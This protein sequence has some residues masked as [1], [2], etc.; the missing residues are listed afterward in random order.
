VHNN[1]KKEGFSLL[2]RYSMISFLC[3]VIISTLTGLLLS[4]FLTRNTLQLDAVGTQYFIQ[5]LVESEKASLY[6]SIKN[7]KKRET[8]FSKI[9]KKIIEN[10][11]IIWVKAY[12]LDGTVLW[13]NDKNFIGHRFMPNP[14]LIRALAGEMAVSSGTS[15]KPLKGEHVFDKE[16]PYFAEIYLPVWNTSHKQVVGVI[17]IY[18]IPHALFSVINRGTRLVWL[19]AGFGGFF[20]YASLFWIVKRA[21]FVLR[22]QQTALKETN[23]ALKE[24]IVDSQSTAE[25]LSSLLIT[26]GVTSNKRF[27]HDCVR[28]LAKIYDVRYASVGIFSDDSHTAIR[29][30]AVWAGDR[31]VDNFS[32]TLAG[33]PCEDVIDSRIEFISENAKKLYP[34]SV[35]LMEMKVNSY[36][37]APLISSS[38]TTLGIV[39]IMGTQT[40]SLQPWT[41]PLLGIMANRLALELERQSADGAL[42]LAE[43]VFNESIEAILITDQNAD[44][45][46]VNPAF[47]RMTG[48]DEVD[49]IGKNPKLLSANHH[50]EAFYANF[51]HALLNDGV[52]RGEIWNRRKNGEVFPVWQNVSSVRNKGGKIVQFISISSDITEKKASEERIHHL[53]HFDVL[54]DLPNRTSFQIEFKRAVAHATRENEHMA[55]LFLDIDHFKLIND[56]YG[57]LVGDEV[58]KHI[59]QCLVAL[60]REEDLIARLGGDEFIILLPGLRTRT[61]ITA[62]TNKI[63]RRL[64]IPFRHKETEVVTTTSIG[65]SLFPENGRDASTLLKSADIA[66]YRAKALGRNNIQFFTD[67]MNQQVEKRLNMVSDLRKAIEGNEFLLY[68]QPQVSIASGEIIACEALIRWQH[69][70]QGLIL[71]GLFIP[72]AEESGLIKPLSS[73]VLETACKQWAQWHRDGLAPITMAVN[74][75]GRQFNSENMSP[76]IQKV[77]TDSGMDPKY[78][79]LELTESVLMLNVKETSKTLGTLRDMGISLSVDDFGTGYSSLAYLKRFPINKLKID[80]SFVKDLGDDPDDDAIVVAT[81][82]MAHNLHLTAIAEGVET[83]H[84]LQFLKENGCDQFQGYHFSHPL[85]SGEITQLLRKVKPPYK[86][87]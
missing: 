11:E 77:V 81:I 79:E 50:D 85:P 10:P 69:P 30:L 68:Y 32:Y 3:I 72:I 67:A 31:I 55:L 86:K 6:F 70:K 14:E 51:W 38:K 57:H 1:R 37:G 56:A 52:W 53:A 42:K 48:Y 40:L 87:V 49:V 17:E 75:S 33:T 35:F 74:L 29:T 41:K 62:I 36:F 47:K 63:L 7:K 65:I 64:E 71:P 54:T 4:R 28:D 73:W 22:R 34:K 5:A 39:S 66:M 21:S 16:I 43:S 23:V 59:G 19:T 8:K 27:F 24:K 26:T 61:E 12:D 83:A 25:A 15:G 84:Q 18:K 76:M 46:R 80:Q 58:L 2:W 13:A 60:I 82:T 44:I 9:F 78:L 20:L 45:L